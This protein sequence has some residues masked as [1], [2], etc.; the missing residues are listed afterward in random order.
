M[1][2][3][4]EPKADALMRGILSALERAVPGPPNG[5]ALVRDALDAIPGLQEAAAGEDG[6]D[7][8]A[9]ERFRERVVELLKSGRNPV[10]LVSYRNQVL[11]RAERGR[12]DG[13][14]SASLGRSALQILKDEF[15]ADQLFDDLA[16][17]DLEEIDETLAD[18]AEDAPP[19][20]DIP[21]WVPESHWWWRAPKRTDMS[22]RERRFRL[23]GG[24][25]DW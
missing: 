14:E 25:L 19:I 9:L 10:H 17:D 8:N 4:A 21:S 23:Y 15:P 16:R 24:E 13:Y 3:E 1:T 22:D 11:E 2:G 20:Q 18:A 12:T 5:K 7:A 6:P